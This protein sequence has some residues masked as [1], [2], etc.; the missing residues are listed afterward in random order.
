MIPEDQVIYSLFIKDPN[1]K[2][3]I[4]REDTATDT[5]PQNEEEARNYIKTNLL[6]VSS[7]TL[8]NY[9]FVNSIPS[10]LPSTKQPGLNYILISTPDFLEITGKPEWRDIWKQK[11]PN[12]EVGCIAFSRIG[13]N[14][15]HT[16]ALIY[17]SRLWVNGGY[18]LLEL[19]AQKGIWETVESFS[20]VQIN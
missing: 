7:E 4:V 19:N 3:V 17:V 16:Q 14:N 12:S 6:K 1:G 18:Y 15:S 2:T 11:Y 20:N 10:K 9:L 8:N 5:F 13:F